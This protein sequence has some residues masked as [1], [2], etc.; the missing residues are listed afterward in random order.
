MCTFISKQWWPTYVSQP[1]PLEKSTQCFRYCFHKNARN[2]FFSILLKTGGEKNENHFHFHFISLL[3]RN[4]NLDSRPFPPYTTTTFPACLALFTPVPPT[5]TI[6]AFC[7]RLQQESH[8]PPSLQYTP[9]PPIVL[10]PS[11][12]L[13]K[14]GIYP[15]HGVKSNQIC[16]EV[17]EGCGERFVLLQVLWFWN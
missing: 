1:L 11:V 5:V 9:E 8:C 12:V 17:R 10:L 16:G 4:I 2:P 14:T 3:N 13:W 6:A 7:L 15:L